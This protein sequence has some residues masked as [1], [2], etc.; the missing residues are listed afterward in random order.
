MYQ[1]ERFEEY[2]FEADV[3][4]NTFNAEAVASDFGFSVPEA[5][6]M[7]QSY[8]DAQNRPTSKT[9]FVLNRERGTRTRNTMWHVGVKTRDV[10]ELSHQAVDDFRNRLRRYVAPTLG[11]MGQLNSR[12]VP[13]VEACVKSLDA[14]LELLVATLD[15]GGDGI[16]G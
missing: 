4:G 16:Y 10:R 1:W 2:L 5:S 11:R 15:E 3:A 7:I 9:L 6:R 14:G 8:L 13:I 12:A